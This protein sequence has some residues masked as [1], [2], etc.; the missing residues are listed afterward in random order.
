MYSVFT[1]II[2]VKYVSKRYCEL[3][4][5][6]AFSA[7]GKVVR[8]LRRISARAPHFLQMLAGLGR[9]FQEFDIVIYIN[10]VTE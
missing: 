1:R 7:K 8:A 10:K 3:E 9:E 2:V 4:A 6:R 5:W